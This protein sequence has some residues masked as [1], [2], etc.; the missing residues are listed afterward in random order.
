M[1]VFKLFE[2]LYMPKIGTIH[3]AKIANLRDTLQVIGMPFFYTAR[4][5][6]QAQRC[7]FQKLKSWPSN[8]FYSAC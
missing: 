1:P 2:H 5:R 3:R 7:M 8:T 6:A 4:G